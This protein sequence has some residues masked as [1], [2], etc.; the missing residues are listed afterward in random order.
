MDM[1]SEHP[2]IRISVCTHSMVLS[3]VQA[4]EGFHGVVAVAEYSV[5]V[6]DSV[7]GGNKRS[8]C[9]GAIDEAQAINLFSKG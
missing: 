5:A 4:V 6:E 1:D 7:V 2:I 8:G 9:M 3:L